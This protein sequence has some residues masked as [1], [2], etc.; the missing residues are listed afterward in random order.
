MKV[1]SIINITIKEALHDKVLYSLLIFG[2][3][4]VIS[5]HFAGSI[6]PGEKDRMTLDVGLVGMGILSEILA[7][8]YGCFTFFKELERRTLHTLISKPISRTQFFLGKYLGICCVLLMIVFLCSLVFL[9]VVIL[10]HD[11][12]GPN[13]L[14][15][16]NLPKAI[17]MLYME[18]VLLTALAFFFSV[19]TASPI[20]CLLI[21]GTLFVLG[22]YNDLLKNMDTMFQKGLIIKLMHRLAYVL[23]NFQYFDVNS[24]AASF[25]PIPMAFIGA[26]TLYG[27]VYSAVLL[28]MGAFVF[29]RRNLP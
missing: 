7:L 2:C 1:L 6:T 15:S 11:G 21:T 9:A 16:W 17:L 13:I 26:A 14:L 4:I 25:K 23:P 29:S 27:V 22:L 12:K 3:F 18:V 10:G 20:V 5:A 8:Y 28:M 24:L 19:I